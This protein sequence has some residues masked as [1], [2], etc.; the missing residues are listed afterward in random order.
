MD[1]KTQARKDAHTFTLKQFLS[2]DSLSSAVQVV[3]SQGRRT[4][5]VSFMDSHQYSSSKRRDSQKLEKSYRGPQPDELSPGVP[6]R[7][8]P[9]RGSQP[10]GPSPGSEPL[11]M[12]SSVLSLCI[13]N[14]ISKGFF[15]IRAHQLKLVFTLVQ[16]TLSS[17]SWTFFLLIKSTMTRCLFLTEHEMLSQKCQPQHASPGS[18]SKLWGKL[19]VKNQSCLN[20]KFTINDT[21]GISCTA[22]PNVKTTVQ[23]QI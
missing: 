16:I 8:V 22:S 15:P 9:A 12:G 1:G 6:A 20:A 17:Q 13:K 11:A 2:V 18:H 21:P 5:R 7:G 14:F 10:G 19:R 3:V 23:R 4:R